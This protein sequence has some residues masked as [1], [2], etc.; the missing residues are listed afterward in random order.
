[1]DKPSN[2]GKSVSLK[3]LT[4]SKSSPSAHLI[5]LPLGLVG[6]S[7]IRITSSASSI[8]GDKLASFRSSLATGVGESSSRSALRP[9]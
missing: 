1:M 4:F 2:T 3:N 5:L 6:D 8:L 7:S 9:P